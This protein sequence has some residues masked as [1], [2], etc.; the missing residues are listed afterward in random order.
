MLKK[1]PEWSFCRRII[2]WRRQEGMIQGISFFMNEFNM[3]VGSSFSP[4]LALP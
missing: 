2:W 1:Y 4:L 3:P